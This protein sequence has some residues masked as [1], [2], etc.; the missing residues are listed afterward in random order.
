LAAFGDGHLRILRLYFSELK[1]RFLNQHIF[2]LRL[3]LSRARSIVFL[4]LPR[5]TLSGK[6]IAA[7]SLSRLHFETAPD[8]IAP[9]KVAL[10]CARSRSLFSGFFLL[11]FFQPIATALLRN[12]LRNMRLQKI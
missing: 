9:F 11:V 5:R 12:Y 3:I 4:L 1:H 8:R 10:E 6:T 7:A 2:S